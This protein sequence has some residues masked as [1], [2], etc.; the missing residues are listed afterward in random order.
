[1]PCFT[2]LCYSQSRYF[3]F[4]SL[5]SLSLSSKI[6][7]FPLSL[8]RISSS[9][10]FFLSCSAIA[11]SSSNKS[12]LLANP[13]T[14]ATWG[15]RLKFRSAMAAATPTSLRFLL[16]VS[17]TLTLLNLAASNSEGDALYTLK[18]SLSDPDNVLQSWDPTLVS[19]CTWFHV[20]CNQD[21]RVTRVYASSLS[22]SL[23]LFCSFLWCSFPNCYCLLL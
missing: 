5:L 9:H 10:C 13:N 14:A 12:S 6:R 4:K 2:A 7:F 23:S 18:R 8:S 11:A 15:V 22:L 1:M 21:N 20:T 16:S 19:P 3:L 17:V